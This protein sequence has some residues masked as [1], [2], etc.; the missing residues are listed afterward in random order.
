V[1]LDGIIYKF[2]TCACKD[3]VLT[4]YNLNSICPIHVLEKQKQNFLFS[5]HIAALFY[6]VM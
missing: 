3:V 6:S 2:G 5:L 1:T 4:V